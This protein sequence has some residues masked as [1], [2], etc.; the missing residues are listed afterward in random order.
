MK[1]SLGCEAVEFTPGAGE[2]RTVG[3]CSGAGAF[4]APVPEQSGVQAFVT[5]EAKHHELLAARQSGLTLVVAGHFHT[6]AVVLDPL[7]QKLAAA[8]PA[9]S[10]RVASSSAAP[11]RFV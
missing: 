11:S 5:G 3:L 7:C 9:V 4:C 1:E 10:F 2:I 8:F 6:E